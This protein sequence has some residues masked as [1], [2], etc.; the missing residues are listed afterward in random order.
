[1]TNAF[2]RIMHCSLLCLLLVTTI[3]TSRAQQ[4]ATDVSE[5][6]INTLNAMRANP[7]AFIPVIDAYQQQVRSFVRDKKAL[8]KAVAEIKK[9][10]ASQQ[11]LPALA[12]DSALQRAAQDHMEDGAKAGFLG[13]IGSDKSNPATRAARYG[14]FS[15]LSEAITYGSLSTSLMLAAFLVDEST[16][17]RGHRE[18]MLN[19]TF[20]VVGVAY[21]QHPSYS[22]QLVVLLG[23]RQ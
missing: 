11:P 13:H 19:P 7:A 3:V 16:P 9:I 23:V 22:S 14:K 15:S 12:A 18:A 4:P 1:M 17:S 20:T 21:G 5:E 8:S 6:F 2:V 10:L